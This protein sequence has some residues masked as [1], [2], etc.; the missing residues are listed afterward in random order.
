MWDQ[1]ELDIKQMIDNKHHPPIIEMIAERHQDQALTKPCQLFVSF[2]GCT[3]VS[4]E[5]EPKLEVPF[6]L[7]LSKL[8]CMY[9]LKFIIHD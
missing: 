2:E 9:A 7:P 6:L 1:K 4:N 3:T 8:Q 5:M